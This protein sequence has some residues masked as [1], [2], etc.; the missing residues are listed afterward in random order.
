MSSIDQPQINKL[1]KLQRLLLFPYG[2]VVIGLAWSGFFFAAYKIIFDIDPFLWWAKALFILLGWIIGAIVVLISNFYYKK[3]RDSQ[4]KA[5]LFIIPE[6]W[7]LDSYVCS[8]IQNDMTV[9]L[10][11]DSIKCIIEV[12]NI[13]KRYQMKQLVKAYKKRGEDFFESK[14]WMRLHKRM[15]GSFYIVGDLKGRKSNGN[16]NLVFHNLQMLVAY[17]SNIKEEHKA[18]LVKAI[19]E[20]NASGILINRN[21]EY[22]QLAFM[23]ATYVGVIE[24]LLGIVFLVSGFPLDAFKIH[25]RLVANK[26]ISFRNELLLSDAKKYLKKELASIVIALS[27]N[28]RFREA[29]DIISSYEK[30]HSPD[31]YSRILLARTLVMQC[32]TKEEYCSAIPKAM[33]VLSRLEVEE[34]LRST[35]LQNRA[36]LYFLTGN[37]TEAEKALRAANKYDHGDLY[38]S[39]IEYCDWV[40]TKD[41]K[42]FEKGVAL[43]TRAYAL[44][45][46]SNNLKNKREAFSD[47]IEYYNDSENY[48]SKKA[49]CEIEAIDE[50]LSIS[51]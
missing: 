48:F 11:S 37:I 41:S 36:Y 10:E 20:H 49:Q 24:F 18:E 38:T 26:R 19:R 27:L 8:D 51:N 43:Y 46:I 35:L 31:D 22:E 6:N 42:E 13:M 39:A 32:N 15:K 5:Y 29:I 12:P 30:N 17:S 33:D 9:R 21:Y 16:D 28:E 34:N 3:T 23:S 47:V 4:L 14:R 1:Y 40:L 45:K 44:N 2:I 50:K 7:E 25:S